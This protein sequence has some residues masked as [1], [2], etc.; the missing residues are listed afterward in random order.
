[1]STRIYAHFEKKDPKVFISNRM[2]Y[3]YEGSNCVHL[4]MLSY[5]HTSFVNRVCFLDILI[6]WRAWTS[7]PDS[8][9]QP[10]PLL[11]VFCYT[12]RLH[13][14]Y[15]P[16]SRAGGNEPSIYFDVVCLFIYN[17]NPWNSHDFRKI[18]SVMICFN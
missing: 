10:V 16:H 8:D 13:N 15:N 9:E 11:P 2:L 12:P 3:F 1:M 17:W 4:N 7:N 5:G 6:C 18:A 14:L